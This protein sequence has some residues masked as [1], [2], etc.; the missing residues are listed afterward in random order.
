MTEGTPVIAPRAVSS[1]APAVPGQKT[2][3]IAVSNP[4][5]RLVSRFRG[6]ADDNDNFHLSFADLMSLLLVFFVVLF[7]MTSGRRSTVSEAPVVVRQVDAPPQPKAL[8]AHSGADPLLF[9]AAG[10]ADGLAAD[11]FRRSRWAAGQRLLG[12]D[13]AVDG[14]L[15]GGAR[16]D[17]ARRQRRV[18]SLLAQLRL[19]AA[20][21]APSGQIRVFMDE[22]HLVIVLAE[23]ITFASAGAELSG[24]VQGLLTK[25]ARLAAAAELRIAVAGHTD[26]RPVHGG[27]LASNWE[28]SAVRA[29]AVA[30][31]LIR[32][33]VSA[34][35]VSIQ[36]YAATRPVADNATAQGRARNRRVEIRLSLPPEA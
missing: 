28:L 4:G 2:V 36:G 7:A 3:V 8:P 31:F 23:R 20:A 35:R 30:K 1:P 14:L 12:Q 10:S 27:R 26:D 24:Q 11:A 5:G 33:G 16:P 17:L 19:L 9:A 18:A 22:H 32:S 15:G 21:A 6:E 13:S 34:D 25:L 29:A